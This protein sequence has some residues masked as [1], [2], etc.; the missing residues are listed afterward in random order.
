MGDTEAIFVKQ[1]MQFSVLF[2][3]KLAEYEHT[4]GKKTSR[5]HL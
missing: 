3:T 2:T 5:D 4:V 1:R